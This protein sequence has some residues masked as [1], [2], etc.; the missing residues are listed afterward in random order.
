MFFGRCRS[1][2][3]LDLRTLAIREKA[4]GP[5]HRDVA[6]SLTY[7]AQVYRAQGQYARAEPLYQRALA[8]QEKSLGSAHPTVRDAVPAAHRRLAV[9]SGAHSRAVG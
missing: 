2:W 6:V 4:L 3:P 1:C 8:I 9:R 7:L 5:E